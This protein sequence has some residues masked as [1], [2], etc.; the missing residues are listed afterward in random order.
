ME[1]PVNRAVNRAGL[2]GDY[3]YHSDCHCI[4]KDSWPSGRGL[5]VQGQPGQPDE[6]LSQKKIQLHGRELA[7]QAII[8]K[9]LAQQ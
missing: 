4:L 2:R 8:G 6:T 7:Q 3:I 1:I 5:K 9:Q